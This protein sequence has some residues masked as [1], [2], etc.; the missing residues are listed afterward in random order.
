LAL[1]SIN[2]FRVPKFAWL[3]R[4]AER[5]CGVE[6][7]RASMEAYL[8]LMSL[9]LE[10]REIGNANLAKLGLGEGRCTVL[11]LLLE[12]QPEPLSHSR[13]AE[14]L[15]VTKGSITGL[16]DGLERDGLVKR[17]D[18]SED[19]RLRYISLTPAGQELVERLMPDKFRRIAGLLAGLTQPERETLVSLLLKVQ[20]GL[21]AYRSD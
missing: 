20:D 14:L 21:P 8:L 5:Y 9:A 10:L 2:P 7:D 1:C 15:L 11:A 3:Q 12:S 6:H 17:E 16:V 13:L 19:R 4:I 18:R